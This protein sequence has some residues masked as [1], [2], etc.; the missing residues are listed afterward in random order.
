MQSARKSRGIPK[1]PA[2]LGDLSK[3]FW[4]TV[5]KGWELEPH[6]VRLLQIACESWDRALEAREAVSAI[7]PY[8]TDHRTGNVKP[9]PGIAVE[10]QAR[11]QFIAALREIGLDV[12]APDS[13]RA[14]GLPVYRKAG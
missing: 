7:G 10:Q 8:F 9:H 3:G 1:P 11:K 5:T 13:P 12:K 6:H 4:R 14:P 2:H